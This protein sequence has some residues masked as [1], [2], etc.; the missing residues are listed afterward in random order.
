MATTTKIPNESQLWCADIVIEDEAYKIKWKMD[1]TVQKKIKVLLK[2]T[3][4][5]WMMPAHE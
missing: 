1:R 2:Q 4:M 3:T 5:E